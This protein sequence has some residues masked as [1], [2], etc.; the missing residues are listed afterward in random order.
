[1]K[2]RFASISRSRFFFWLGVVLAILIRLG[3]DLGSGYRGDIMIYLAATWKIMH[4][5]IQSAYHAVE[6]VPPFD[7]PPMLLYP[8]WLIGWF[9]YHLFG[10]AFPLPGIHDARLLRFLLRLP[11]LLA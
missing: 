5:G 6:G 2:I 9:Y 11:N 3:L 8:F 1:M 4:F 10:P 7:D